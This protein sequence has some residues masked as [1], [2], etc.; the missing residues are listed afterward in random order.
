MNYLNKVNIINSVIEEV[1][2]RI[3][4]NSIEGSIYVESDYFK[5]SF[6]IGEEPVGF[7]IVSDKVDSYKSYSIELELNAISMDY[8]FN[9]VDSH[10]FEN[11]FKDDATKIL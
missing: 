1:R 3:D 10:T 7:F 2:N 6:I 8:V 11:N 5:D 9:V 4:L